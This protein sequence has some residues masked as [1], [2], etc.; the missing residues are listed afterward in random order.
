MSFEPHKSKSSNKI[1][2][3]QFLTFTRTK[4]VIATK[5]NQ[6][7]KMLVVKSQLKIPLSS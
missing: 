2:E 3:S 4:L 7:P 1:R 6:L 5:I